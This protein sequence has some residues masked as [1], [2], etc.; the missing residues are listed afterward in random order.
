MWDEQEKSAKFGCEKINSE[1]SQLVI[2]TGNLG[3]ASIPGIIVH[4]Q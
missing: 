1:E 4:Q 2:V 3:S